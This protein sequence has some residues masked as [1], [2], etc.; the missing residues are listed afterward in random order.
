VGYCTRCECRECRDERELRKARSVLRP[1][2]SAQDFRQG[3][4]LRAANFV[5]AARRD[6][7]LP[8]LDGSIR[9]SDCPAPAKV[10][11]HR[12]YARP[13]DVVPV[14]ESCN[15]RRGLGALPQAKTFAPMVTLGGA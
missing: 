13:F 4:R 5:L 14:C 3:W 15:M 7:L 10:Y 6:G 2:D 1:Q 8:A 11:E 12:D 9:C